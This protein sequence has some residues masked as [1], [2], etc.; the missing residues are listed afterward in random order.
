MAA[1]ARGR[2]GAARAA[3]QL[4]VHVLPEAAPGHLQGHLVWARPRA[5]PG[6]GV[7]AALAALAGTEALRFGSC[8]AAPTAADSPSQGHGLLAQAVFPTRG[9]QNRWGRLKSC[10]E[11]QRT[12][13]G[14]GEEGAGLGILALLSRGK[15]RA[16]GS[17]QGDAVW[18]G[19]GVPF[20]PAH[21]PPASPLPCRSS[22]G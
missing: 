14:G 18:Q 16:A 1:R 3:P 7:L 17:P 21:R 4:V 15:A 8:S 19:L 13:G 9:G 5:P 20:L 10:F 11:Q 12:S 2:A 22:T 6:G